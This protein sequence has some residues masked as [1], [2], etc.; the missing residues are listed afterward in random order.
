VAVPHDLDSLTELLWEA[1]FVAADEEAEDLLRTADGDGELLDALVA[2]RLTGEPIAWITGRISF[3]GLELRVDPG[4]YVPRWHT[5]PLARRA[6]ER[7]PDEGTAIDLC[8]GTGAIAAVLAA[9]RPAARVVATDLDER[10]VVCARANGV[11]AYHGD[12]FAPVPAELFGRV[13]VVAGV[14]PYVPTPSLSL[15]QRDTF[16]FESGLSYDGGDD[17]AD[18]LRRVLVDSTAFL[19]PGGALL[20]E[21][22]GDQA[23]LLG[24]EL[25]RLRY[26]DVG[27]LFDEEDDVRGIEVTLTGPRS[28]R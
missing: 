26:G 12:L 8:T 1:G 28:P 4:V 13:D 15:L 3:C 5:E 27:L 17:G 24:P 14:V 21:L 9:A 22:G 7:L 25:E 10:A 20:L 6:A 18:V 23:D 16:A 11:D 19:R 2:R